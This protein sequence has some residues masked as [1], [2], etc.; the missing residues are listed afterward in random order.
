MTQSTPPQSAAEAALEEPVV[1]VL[2]RRVS[3]E[4]RVVS[5]DRHVL[6]DGLLYFSQRAAE[7]QRE[8][9]RLRE[10]VTKRFNEGLA[11]LERAEKAEAALAEQEA[12]IAELQFYKD[13]WRPKKLA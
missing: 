11:L 3:N 12:R 7:L 8:V 1:I 10:T 13:A 9:E 4:V 6:A 2:A 5:N